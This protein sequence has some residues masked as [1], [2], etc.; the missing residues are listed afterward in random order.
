[1]SLRVVCLIMLNR[2]PQAR[3]GGGAAIGAGWWQ[4]KKALTMPSGRWLKWSV[5]WTF[6]V[7]P[8][9]PVPWTVAVKVPLTTL[10]LW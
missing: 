1:M 8:S 4:W 9:E 3:Q 6:N 10:P 2:F 7:D 5:M